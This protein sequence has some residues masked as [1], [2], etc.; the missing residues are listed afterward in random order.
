MTE[1]EFQEGK[2]KIRYVT[3]EEKMKIISNALIDKGACIPCLSCGDRKFYL[4]EGS[5]IVDFTEIEGGK[6]M[7]NATRASVILVICQNCGHTRTYKANI[8]GVSPESFVRER[9]TILRR[10]M[11]GEDI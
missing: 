4:E 9:D 2:S 8:L 10:L 1:S 11:K 6:I 5:M 7:T 3:D